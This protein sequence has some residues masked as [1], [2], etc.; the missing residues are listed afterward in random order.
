VAFFVVCLTTAQGKRAGAVD[1]L[2][3]HHVMMR[4]VISPKKIG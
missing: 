2:V 4:E 3:V 1:L